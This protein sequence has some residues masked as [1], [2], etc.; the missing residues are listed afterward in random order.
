MQ[1]FLR[2]VLLVFLSLGFALDQTATV[3]RNVDLRPDSTGSDPIVKLTPSPYVQHGEPTGGYFHMKAAGVQMGF[4]WKKNIR[5]EA[6]TAQR[7]PGSTGSPLSGQALFDALI[8]RRKMAMGQPLMENG[9]VVCGPTGDAK[10][11]PAQALNTNK[12]R[13]DL[14]RQTDYV[15]IN[16]D[17]L[18]NLPENRVKDFQGAPVIVV[19]FLS[20]E[21]KVGNGRAG[22]SVNC[23]LLGEGEVDWVLYLTKSAMQGIK[24]A[25]I[26]ET[27]PRT[28]P[29]HKWTTGM[30]LPLVDSQTLVRT[31]GWLMQDKA[32]QGGIGTQ[33]AT[34]WEVHPIT[35]IEVQKNG[36]WVDLDKL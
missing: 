34:L 7:N 6:V 25:I 1:R 11:P 9:S 15:K 12:N 16:W 27:T 30:L 4:S 3:T 20:H 19:G 13:T 26:V 23:H 35:R 32:H 18:K 21:I 24:D 8:A 29:S 33:R 36:H 10:T 2:I 31:S 5:I 14:P 28:R 22:E 17:D